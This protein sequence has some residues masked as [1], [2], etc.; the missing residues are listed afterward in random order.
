MHDAL[1][2]QLEE[3]IVFG[4]IHP[5]ERLIEE[6][7]AERFKEKRHVIRSVLEQLETA[8][9]VTRIANRGAFVRELTPQEVIEI[10]E[11]REILEVSAARRTPLPAPKAVLNEM[12]AV[13]KQHS[14]AIAAGDLRAVFYLNIEFHKIQ[15]SACGNGTL[16][17]TIA[18]HARQA[19]LIRTVK[20]AE[21]GHLKSV[22]AEHCA[23]L[24]AMGGGDRSALVNV[25]KTHLPASRDAYVR[26]YEQRHV[27][28]RAVR[29]S[30]R[31]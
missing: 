31:P 12:R 8:G 13:Q 14:A 25:V 18:D 17:N 9:F 6:E 27:A 11:V 29:A 24:A 1:V 16:A 30:K 2:R 3:D 28:P 23:I 21:P 20:Y 26:A 19:H 22:E 4:V 15:F 5:R 10:Y 7:L